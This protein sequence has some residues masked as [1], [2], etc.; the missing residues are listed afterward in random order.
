VF[1]GVKIRTGGRGGS[2][3]RIKQAQKKKER[4]VKEGD[5][6]RPQGRKRK[7]GFLKE[8]KRKRCFIGRE[9]TKGVTKVVIT[10]G[11]SK[12]KARREGGPHDRERT[13]LGA[14]YQM[15]GL[16]RWALFGK[17]GTQKSCKGFVVECP[18][19]FSAQGRGGGGEP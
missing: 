8:K 9:R 10:S 6:D 13:V 16:L 17:R 2:T 4:E 15:K 19:H 11:L 1:G 3:C 12:R 7:R 14:R 5:S 18:H